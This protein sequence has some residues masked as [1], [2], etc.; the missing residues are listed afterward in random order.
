[1]PC[2]MRLPCLRAEEEAIHTRL[3]SGL[4]GLIMVHLTALAER[5]MKRLVAV[6][7]TI[8]LIDKWVPAVKAMNIGWR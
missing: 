1:M 4:G 2:Q 8:A 7:A 5:E 6:A 3:R